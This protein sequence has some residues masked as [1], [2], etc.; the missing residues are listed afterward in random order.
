MTD[1]TNVATNLAR[2]KN[3]RKP[4]PPKKN[5]RTKVAPVFKAKAQRPF[6]SPRGS[7]T[8]PE[9]RARPTPGVNPSGGNGQRSGRG[10]RPF[11]GFPIPPS[12]RAGGGPDRFLPPGETVHA[13]VSNRKPKANGAPPANA[14]GRS[15]PLPPGIQKKIAG[16]QSARTFAPKRGRSKP[17]RY[18]T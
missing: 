4:A 16:A 2:K 7:N 6:Q 9:P 14:S 3:P 1:P 17:P 18:N 13:L 8:P 12:P 15:F 5:R 10:P 11:R